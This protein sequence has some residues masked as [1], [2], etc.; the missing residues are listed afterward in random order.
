MSR[1]GGSSG[2]LER[3]CDAVPAG[4]GIEDVAAGL[5][6]LVR[7]E[8][9]RR[10]VGVYRVGGGEV[11]NLAWSGPAAPAHPSF[12]SGQGL[13]GAALAS[14]D[15]VCSNDA[16]ADPRCLTNQ[17][18]TGSGLVVP[19]IIAGEVVG[20]L[21]VEDPQTSAFGAT[22]EAFFEEIATALSPLYRRAGSE[23][24]R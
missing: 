18:T 2:I 3:M 11:V 5:A 24:G 10:W 1:P 20:T 7:R 19:V 17:P 12:P 8:S 4:A 15:T 22:D 16:A 14:R 23:A 6:D 13:T 9:G 21:D